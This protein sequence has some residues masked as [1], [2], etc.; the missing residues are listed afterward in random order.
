MAPPVATPARGA[1]KPPHPRTP[2]SGNPAE[3]KR[4][5]GKNQDPDKDRVIQ[6]LRK[7]G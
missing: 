6:E 2:G 3:T 4:M 1:S 7:A 5:R